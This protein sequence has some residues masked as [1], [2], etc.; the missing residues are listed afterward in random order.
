MKIQME[1]QKADSNF[2]AIKSAMNKKL[3]DYEI[4]K[5][6]DEKKKIGLFDNKEV[7]DINQFK[8][9]TPKVKDAKEIKKMINNNNPQTNIERLNSINNEQI[10]LDIKVKG[11]SKRNSLEGIQHI[12]NQKQSLK[13]SPQLTK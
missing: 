4:K 13:L 10:S 9:P 8:N 7:L 11:N 5:I 2:E 1:K 12:K 3:Q 6:E